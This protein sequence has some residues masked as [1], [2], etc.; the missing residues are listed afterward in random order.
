M[1][2]NYPHWNLV[3]LAVYETGYVAVFILIFDEDQVA[4]IIFHTAATA[5]R[6]NVSRRE[7]GNLCSRLTRG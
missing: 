4:T 5:R 6:V 2:Y 1:T 7:T 3:F